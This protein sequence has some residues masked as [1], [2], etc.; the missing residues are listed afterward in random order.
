MHEVKHETSKTS[1]SAVKRSVRTKAI[2][3]LGCR[4]DTEVVQCSDKEWMGKPLECRREL[5]TFHLKNAKIKYLLYFQTEKAKCPEQAVSFNTRTIVTGFYEGDT[6]TFSC[7]V[8]NVLS[9]DIDT[10][11]CNSSGQW[12]S[13]WPLCQGLPLLGNRHFDVS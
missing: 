1:T 6:A 5:Y 4:G 11:T 13:P 2:L 9:S 10:V 8:G 7:T 12:S 3:V